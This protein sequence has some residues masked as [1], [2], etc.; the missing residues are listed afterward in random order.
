MKVP[1]LIRSHRYA[2]AIAELQQDLEK[3]PEDMVAVEGMA[4]ALRA[5]GDYKKALLFFERLARYE[6]DNKIAN[7]LAPGRVAWQIEIA[8]LHWLTDDHPGAIRLMHGLAAGVF[9]GSI[10]YGD[11]AGGMSQGLLL[12]YMAV[13]DNLAEE[14]IRIELPEQSGYQSEA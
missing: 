14:V 1:E 8:C 2:Q 10:K 7:T 3:N 6:S 11:A 4:K 9:D 5:N 12:F 13:S